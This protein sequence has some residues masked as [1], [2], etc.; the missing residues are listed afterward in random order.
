MSFQTIPAAYRPTLAAAAR[1]HSVGGTRTAGSAASATQA[2]ATTSQPGENSVPART[3]RS[4]GSSAFLVSAIAFAR[5]GRG[6]SEQA[7]DV[8]VGDEHDQGQHEHE[9]DDLAVGQDARAHRR[10]LDALD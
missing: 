4:Q 3:S 5:D 6:P 2:P 9:A 10:A 7:Q 8:V 1:M